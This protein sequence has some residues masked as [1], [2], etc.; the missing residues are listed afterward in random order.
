[1]NKE[2]LFAAIARNAGINKWIDRLMY[3]GDAG[4]NYNDVNCKDCLVYSS[5]CIIPD[6][7]LNLMKILQLRNLWN[8][9]YGKAGILHYAK[10]HIGVDSEDDTKLLDCYETRR[11]PLVRIVNSIKL[12][13]GVL[14]KKKKN[15]SRSLNKL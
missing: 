13:H 2:L 7:T 12:Y 1:M 6:E 14:I 9:W 11:A 4:D 10:V 5:C 8:T 15:S 3:C